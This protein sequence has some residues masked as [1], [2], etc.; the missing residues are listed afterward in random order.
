MF[1]L[2]N[3][4]QHSSNHTRANTA[5]FSSDYGSAA[6]KKGKPKPLDLQ[7]PNS[8][9]NGL[10]ELSDSNCRTLKTLEGA[11]STFS[12]PSAIAKNIDSLSRSSKR[13]SLKYPTRHSFDYRRNSN[14]NGLTA[15][16]PYINNIRK[17]MQFIRTPV[18]SSFKTA[19]PSEKSSP[20]RLVNIVC[21]SGSNKGNKKKAKSK[22][23]T[24]ALRK[25]LYNSFAELK[26][27]NQGPP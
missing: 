18:R 4:I 10:T 11:N 2:A 24:Q 12:R 5:C 6:L 21:P 1:K 15:M 8:K 14:G 16:T 23:S 20:E 13:T 27:P 9:L 3:S 7:I 26:T 19:S 25:N 17:K 22:T